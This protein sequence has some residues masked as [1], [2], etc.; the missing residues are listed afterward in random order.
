[1]KDK[2]L[3]LLIIIISVAIPLV[4]LILFYV[5]PPDIKLNFNIH[6]LP[7]FHA[8]LNFTTAVLLIAGYIFI[9]QK[10]IEY[11]RYS[12]MGAFMLSAIFLISYV[13]YHMFTE[14]TRFGGEGIIRSIYYFLLLSHILLAVAIVPM[15]LITLSRAW[16]EKYALHKR[17]AKYTLP[18]WLYVAVTGVLVYIMISP[19][20]V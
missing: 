15:V 14:P 16:Q 9:R 8:A 1:M 12:M 19:Y 2:T 17:I 6:L 11:H 5:S 18:I 13:T 20:Y 10:K 3:N 4:V 7:P